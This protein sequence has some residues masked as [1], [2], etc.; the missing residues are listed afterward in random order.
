MIVSW[1]LD[2]PD[3]PQSRHRSTWQLRKGAQLQRPISNVK[4]LRAWLR[5]FLFIT[6]YHTRE[7]QQ[8]REA[9]QQYALV[10]ARKHGV[11]EPIGC[12]CG[13]WITCYRRRPKSKPASDYP[14][15][16]DVDNFVKT[17]LD[18]MNGVIVTDDAQI[19]C[20]YVDKQWAPQGC[21]HYTHIMLVTD[22]DLDYYRN[23]H[24]KLPRGLNTLE[25]HQAAGQQQLPV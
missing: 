8:D 18:S 25:L 24:R 1:T 5:S 10:A 16:G 20:L 23:H 22:R 11:R 14:A 9:L 3:A 2:G 19:S 15:R 17:L 7:S 4:E 12:E 21:G 13:V 6:T